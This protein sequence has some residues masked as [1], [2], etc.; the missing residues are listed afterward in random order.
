MKE[1]TR[2]FCRR[3]QIPYSDLQDII[4]VVFEIILVLKCSKSESSEKPHGQSGG[5]A[6]VSVCHIHLLH[7]F[8]SFW[9]LFIVPGVGKS[10]LLLRF[11]D[12]TFS[13]KTR[14]RVRRHPF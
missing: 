2:S 4:L 10:S 14:E 8:S 11:A 3:S 9:L 12:N 1:V 13:G 6:A 5:F 7:D